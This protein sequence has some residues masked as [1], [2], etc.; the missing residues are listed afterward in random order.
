MSTISQTHNMKNVRLID[1]RVQTLLLGAAVI[2]ILAVIFVNVAFSSAAVSMN[3]NAYRLY[4]QGEWAFVPFTPAQA[5]QIFRRGE[6]ASPVSSAE[7]YQ[8]YRQGE[9]ASASIPV[10]A[11][12]LSAYHLSE[13]T[14]VKALSGLDIY[15]LSERTLVDPQA[16]L[17]IYHNSERTSLP[18]QFNPYQRSEWFGE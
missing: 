9:W 10:T 7:A 1:N 15:H 18:V 8:I 2:A 16:G 13:R 4:R 17:A 14:M 5:Y 3:D 11:G 12:D 6:V